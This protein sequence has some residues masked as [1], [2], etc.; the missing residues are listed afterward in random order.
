MADKDFNINDIIDNVNSKK[1]GTSANASTALDISFK[2]EKTKTESNAEDISNENTV[3]EEASVTE[4][5]EVQA[6]T[7]QVEEEHE[8]E[9]KEE[10]TTESEAEQG[11]DEADSVEE[12][13][14]KSEKRKKKAKDETPKKNKKKSKKKKKK[15]KKSGFN[16]SIFGALILVTFILIISLIIA[17]GGISLGM[18]YIGVG[19]SENEITFNIPKNASTDDIAQILVDNQIINNKDLFKLVMKIKKPDTIYPGDITLHASMGYAKI[20]NELSQMRESYETVTITFPE[21]ITLFEAANMLQENGVCTADDF[22][23]EFNKSQDFDFE[24][25]ID[26]SADTFYQMEGF[27]FPDTYEFYVD[28]SAYNVTKIIR[29]H[30]ESIFTDSMYAQ[31]EANNMTLS[32]VMTL[33]SIVQWEANSTEEMPTV[34]S[35]FLNRLSD[36]DTFPS[37]QSDATKKYITKVIDV[38]AN[39][40]ASIEHY[41]DCYDTYECQGLPAG[42]ICNPG[43]DAINAVLYPDDTNYYYFCNNLETGKS[44]FAETLEEHEQNLILAGLA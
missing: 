32:E 14:D 37:L 16:T 38:V 10:E 15:K 43:L 39:N 23:F 33:A 11:S 44:Y 20:I 30:F 12:K 35:V 40:D 17:L 18:E 2:P 1:N 29:E 36:S 3:S 4:N 34:A 22:L 6:D 28:D 27:F 26:T 21:G 31:M 7:P 24:S 41:T 25:K 8:A 5:N 13:D 42:P 9:V 19:K